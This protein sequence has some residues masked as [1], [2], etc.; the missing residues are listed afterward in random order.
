[1]SFTDAKSMSNKAKRSNDLAITAARRAI[2][3]SIDGAATAGK[4]EVS[5]YALTGV[6]TAARSQ[7]MEDLKDAGYDVKVNYPFDQRDSESITISW[8]NA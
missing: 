2:M 7:I 3:S 5:S 6:P 8:E 4:T 1:M